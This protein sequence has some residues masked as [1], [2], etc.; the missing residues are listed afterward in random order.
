MNETALA[1]GVPRV[2][3]LYGWI[4]VGSALLTVAALA[5]ARTIPNS[6]AATVAAGFLVWWWSWFL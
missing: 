2:L 5:R 4:A 1:V 3:E 6:L